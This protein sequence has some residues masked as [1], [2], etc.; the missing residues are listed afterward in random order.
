MIV[1]N[2]TSMGANVTSSLSGNLSINQNSGEIV[3]KN[4]N[5][6]VVRIDQT[7]FSYFD[8][9]SIKRISMGQDDQGRQQIIVFGA[10]GKAQILIGQDPK[11]NSPVIAVT[12]T[13]EDV[14]T[15]LINDQR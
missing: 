6:E 8:E 11:D 12:E 4:G 7:G 1:K 9:Q 5:N 13:G 3:I 14:R 2:I 10:D 15:E